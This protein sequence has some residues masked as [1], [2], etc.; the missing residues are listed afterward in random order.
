MVH[1][2]NDLVY[3]VG[4]Y[5]T[6]DKKMVIYTLSYATGDLITAPQIL[7]LDA[8]SDVTAGAKIILN[9]RP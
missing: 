1:Y 7:D 5:E 6:F 2:V 8:N 4:G 9:S 3:A